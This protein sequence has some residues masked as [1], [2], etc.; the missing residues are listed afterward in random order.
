MDN[1]LVENIPGRGVFVKKLNFKIESYKKMTE[2]LMHFRMLEALLGRE[3]DSRS[4]LL[5]VKKAKPQIQ[6][7]SNK[8]TKGD[9]NNDK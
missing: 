9:E 7:S 8:Q 2:Y 5:K 6:D 3:L 1:S 4:V